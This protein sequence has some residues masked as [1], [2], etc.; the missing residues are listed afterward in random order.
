MFAEVVTGRFFGL[1]SFKE[2]VRF[3][4]KVFSEKEEF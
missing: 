1:A 4:Y 3:Q 2:V